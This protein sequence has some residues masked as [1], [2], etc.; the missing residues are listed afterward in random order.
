VSPENGQRPIFDPRFTLGSAVQ[1]FML[2]AAILWW[3]A[4]QSGRISILEVNASRIEGTLNSID[5]KIDTV[6]TKVTDLALA[7]GRQEQK[8]EDERGNDRSR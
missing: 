4:T 6:D 7:E 2:L 5:Q 8:L 3:A 1:I